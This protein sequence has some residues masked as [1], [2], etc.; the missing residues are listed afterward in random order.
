MIAALLDC[1]D[2]GFQL[3]PMVVEALGGWGPLAQDLF[4]VVAKASAEV[5]GLDVSMAACQLY[6]AM[7][8]ELQR[9]NALAILSHILA[10][11]AANCDN[12]ALAATS[13]SEAALV[14][15]AAATASG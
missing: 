11:S 9:G 5:S 6:Q 8:V 3:V 7:S 2:A 13:R 14:L 15:S 1:Q 10:A 4:R 12:T